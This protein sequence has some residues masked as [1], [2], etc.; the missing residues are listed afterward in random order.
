MGGS[1]EKPGL[2]FPKKERAFFMTQIPQSTTTM[3]QCGG[4]IFL[5]SDARHFVSLPD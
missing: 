3:K 5:K 2:L 4:D 1:I